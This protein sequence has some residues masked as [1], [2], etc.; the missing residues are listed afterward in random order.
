M[1][2]P[3]AITTF[4]VAWCLRRLI[5]LIPLIPLGFSKKISKGSKCSSSSNNNSSNFPKFNKMAHFIL[6]LKIVFLRI[7]FKSQVKTNILRINPTF[8][9]KFFVLLIVIWFVVFFFFFKHQSNLSNR[10]FLLTL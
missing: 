5:K 3:A 6:S 10:Y 4:P 7:R 1:C 9:L 2:Q 8:S